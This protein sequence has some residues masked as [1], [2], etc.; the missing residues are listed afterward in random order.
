MIRLNGEEMRQKLDKV[1]TENGYGQKKPKNGKNY[2]E[3]SEEKSLNQQ[4]L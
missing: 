3:N 1:L 2:S 4:S